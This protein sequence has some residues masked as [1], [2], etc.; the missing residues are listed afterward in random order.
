MRS[1]K[2]CFNTL[3]YKGILKSFFN[4][5]KTKNLLYPENLVTIDNNDMN[6]AV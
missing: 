5:R 2:L 4:F 1:C 3:F 6:F